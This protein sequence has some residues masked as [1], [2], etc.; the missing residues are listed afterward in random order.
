MAALMAFKRI[1]HSAGALT[2]ETPL[3]NKSSKEVVSKGD[4]LATVCGSS[5]R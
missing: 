4:G 1:P 5:F 2:S 3:A